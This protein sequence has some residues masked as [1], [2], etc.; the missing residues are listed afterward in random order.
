MQLLNE[1]SVL[2]KNSDTEAIKLVAALG[3]LAAP[4]DFI[5]QVGKLHSVLDGYD[6]D[7]A[8]EIIDNLQLSLGQA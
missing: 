1:I 4:D 5:E 6:F 7:A 8:L 2:A 3:Q